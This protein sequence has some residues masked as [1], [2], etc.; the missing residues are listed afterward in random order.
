MPQKPLSWATPSLIAVETAFSFRKGRRLRFQLYPGFKTWT[1]RTRRHPAE[2]QLLH[3]PASDS[4][5][6]FENETGEAKDRL[7]RVR[8]VR[9]PW[10]VPRK[11]ATRA[12]FARHPTAALLLE[13][14]TALLLLRQH[15]LNGALSPLKGA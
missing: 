1:F 9:E 12:S 2:E 10:D 5:A 8:G 11:V 13:P 3:G 6:R 15:C 4:H 14:L 7:A